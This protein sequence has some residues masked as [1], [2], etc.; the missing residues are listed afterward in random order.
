MKTALVWFKNDLRLH[1]NETLIKAIE[2]NDHIIPV[3]CFDGAHYGALQFG[4]RRT[5]AIRA[6]F[7]LQSL[8]D[9]DQH[10]RDLGAGLMVVRGKVADE[11]AKLV[12]AYKATTIYAAAEVAD[13]ELG[14]QHEVKEKVR[15]LNCSFKV[16]STATL[17]HPS[18]LPFSPATLPD[19]FTAFRHKVEAASQVR[20]MFPVPERINAPEIAPLQ[21]PGL[22]E[23]NLAAVTVD[24]RAALKF[25]GGET[26]A[27]ARVRY[28]LGESK[29][30]STYKETRNELVGAD[31]S[32]KFSA[33]LANGCLSPRYL[34]H[35][36]KDYEKKYGANDS[37][38]WVVFELLWRDYFRFA[39]Q[40]HGKKFFLK[41]G[42]RGHGPGPIR[43]DEATM[44]QWIN[45]KTGVDFVDAN[46]LEL[47]LTGF[48][49]NRGRQNVASYFCND[50]KLDWRYGAAYFEEQLIDYDVHSNWCNWAYI[51]GVGND[52]RADRYFNIKKQAD[53]YDADGRFRDLWLGEG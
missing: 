9:L 38:Y 25:Y 44:L 27:L 30:V 43:Y 46:M 15:V 41:E 4:F 34:Y 51:A 8:L 1:D 10:L 16:F 3:Y 32:T 21:L 23:L 40:K 42:I 7:I 6:Q 28:Y 50:L 31:Y 26:S 17:Y 5:G 22:S 13:E 29:L 37:T 2:E 19:V 12:L 35:Q 33:W 49:S 45:G 14:L 11:L 48:M 52:P 20:E 36:L 24:P 18:D 39:M 47:K 53:R